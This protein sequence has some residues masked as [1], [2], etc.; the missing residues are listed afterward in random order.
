MKAFF[1]LFNKYLLSTYHVPDM[2]RCLE[3]ISKQNKNSA[4]GN[5]SEGNDRHSLK[6]SST[7]QTESKQRSLR[8]SKELY[9]RVVR[10]TTKI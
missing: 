6:L 4:L 1:Q 8:I 10:K 7:F 5:V 2:I 9:G 3:Y